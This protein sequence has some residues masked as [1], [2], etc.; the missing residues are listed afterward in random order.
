MP[1]TKYLNREEIKRLNIAREAIFNRWASRQ[2]KGS[3]LLR[4]A[5]TELVYFVNEQNRLIRTEEDREYEL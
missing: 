1:G 5:I 3:R 4:D 2:K